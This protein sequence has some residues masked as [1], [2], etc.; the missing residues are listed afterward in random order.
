MAERGDDTFDEPNQIVI[1]AAT[2]RATPP[3][4]LPWRAIMKRV[5]LS[6]VKDD[7]WF[8]YQLEHDPRFVTRMEAARCSLDDGRG[9]P[10][11]QVR[12]QLGLGKKRSL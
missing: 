12:A 6:G 7:D 9:I 1:R 5:P 10:I 2:P 11:E 8:D 4:C 3:P